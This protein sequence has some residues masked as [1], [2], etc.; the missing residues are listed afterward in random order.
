MGSPS[1][2]PP[3]QAAGRQAQVGPQSDVYALGAILYQLLTG[4]PPFA[5]SSPLEI[6]GK[7]MEMDPARPSKSHPETP[8]DL[9]TVC[10]KCLEKRPERRYH[11]ARELAE[12]LGRFLNHEPILAK[13]SHALRRVWSW[14]NRHPWVLAASA[15][16]LVLYLMVLT[17][18]L[19]E[20]NTYLKW[21]IAHP[22]EVKPYAYTIFDSPITPIVVSILVMVSFLPCVEL[23]DRKRRCLLLDRR[24][25]WAYS[26]FGVF[27]IALA[28]LLVFKS[29][30]ANVWRIE[31]WY[32]R[33][34]FFVVPFALFWFG[35]LAVW[36]C[37]RN[38]QSF[39]F[40][41]DRT[42][43]GLTIQHIFVDK[44]I[45]YS[46]VILEAFVMGAASYFITPLW[47]RLTF[48]FHSQVGFLLALCGA[49]W[50]F[51]TGV[52]RRFWNFALVLAICSSAFAFRKFE[53]S[54]LGVMSWLFGLLTGIV[55]IKVSNMRR[56]EPHE[57]LS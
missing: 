6:M 55:L 1:F 49:C 24:Q 45:F 13:P 56:S 3:E 25:L 23:S 5:G 22:D 42:D 20:R 4:Q 10:L 43:K 33:Y 2:M 40:G 11:S 57:S 36:H 47:S 37:L 8:P 51:S 32:T 7:V 30:Y 14:A 16:L 28:T 41:C 52:G 34:V 12:E 54:K 39:T 29:A 44:R 35:I 15:S 27:Q 19:S 46:T 31:L 48:L 38:H 53:G 18:E 26:S 17:Y 9:E 50:W 21:R